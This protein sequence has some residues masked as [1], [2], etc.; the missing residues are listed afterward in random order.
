MGANNC[1]GFGDGGL[2]EKVKIICPHCRIVP[3]A[4]DYMFCYNCGQRLWDK[5]DMSTLARKEG[6]QGFTVG[7]GALP[8]Y[9][10]DR[11]VTPQKRMP[12]DNDPKNAHLIEFLE[13]EELSGIA[14]DIKKKVGI[15]KLDDLMHASEKDVE[16]VCDTLNLKMGER[17]RL[18]GAIRSYREVAK[19]EPTSVPAPMYSAETVQMMDQLFETLEMANMEDASEA[20]SG[21]IM[22]KVNNLKNSMEKRDPAVEGVRGG[23]YDVALEAVPG[24]QDFLP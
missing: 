19:E 23:D 11:E 14:E 8:E 21:A 2:A 7:G 16:E 3:P 18:K 22:E 15:I 9:G 12:E 20:E 1:K 5:N 17:L 10:S 13:K 6:E 4:D 24:T